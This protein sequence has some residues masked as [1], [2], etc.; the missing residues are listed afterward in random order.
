M[1]LRKW[2]FMDTT[3]N[4]FNSVEAKTINSA[5]T[6]IRKKQIEYAKEHGKSVFWAIYESKM[7]TCKLRCILATYVYSNGD[8]KQDIL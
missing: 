6:L 8:I 4:D 3:K 1:K 5:L 7:I 2:Y